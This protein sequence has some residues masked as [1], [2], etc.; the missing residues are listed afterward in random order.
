M[1]CSPHCFDSPNHALICYILVRC[2]RHGEDRSPQMS[3]KKHPPTSFPPLPV[4][5]QAVSRT[6]KARRVH[7]WRLTIYAHRVALS[8]ILHPSGQ[9]PVFRGAVVS[10]WLCLE[11]HTVSRAKKKKERVH[12]LL[13]R[14]GLTLEKGLGSRNSPRTR[15]S[16]ETVGRCMVTGHRMPS[17]SFAELWCLTDNWTF[18]L[19]FSPRLNY[20]VN[21]NLQKLVFIFCLVWP[22][23]CV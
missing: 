21:T 20:L 9:G 10:Q 3:P 4:R 22:R 7:S 6:S 16:L 5:V 19:F 11:L 18:L 17:F 13:I 2:S 23:N 8:E 1:E 15:D 14:N 12:L